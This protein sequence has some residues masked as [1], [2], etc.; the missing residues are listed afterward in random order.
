MQ[1][2]EKVQ[3]SVEVAGGLSESQKAM[4]R[5]TYAPGASESEF[6][7]L[8]EIAKARKLNPILKQIYF[9]KRWTQGRGE[10]WAPQVSID[11]M[12]AMAERTGKY[13]GQDEPE[14]VEENGA[15]VKCTV[16]VYRKDWTRPAVG[17]AYF[18]EYVQKTKEGKPT[19][20]WND[21]PHTMLAKCAESLAL[22][23][24]FPEDMGGLYTAEEMSQADKVPYDADGVIV[25]AAPSEPDL[26]PELTASVAAEKMVKAT[27]RGELLE[28]WSELQPVMKKLTQEQRD[29][30]TALKDARKAELRGGSEAA[31]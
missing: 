24:A 12:R 5:N 28:V 15:V 6:D 19:K 21:M 4:I 3:Q 25:E 22:R 2:L 30:L 31:Q 26:S 10:V 8:W 27:E 1:A 7:V 16:R 13:D 17:V 14:F 20:F 18:K 9:V 11:G 23:K 29:K